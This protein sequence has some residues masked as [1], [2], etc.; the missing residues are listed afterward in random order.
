MSFRDKLRVAVAGKGYAAGDLTIFK[1]NTTRRKASVVSFALLNPEGSL[2]SSQMR[3]ESDSAHG[4]AGADCR[5]VSS[6]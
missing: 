1:N 2:I 6:D 5:I 3:C 4:A